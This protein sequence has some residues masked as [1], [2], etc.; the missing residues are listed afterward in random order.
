MVQKQGEIELRRVGVKNDDVNLCSGTCAPRRSTGA[1]RQSFGKQHCL[2][3]EVARCA[4]VYGALRH[5][6]E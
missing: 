6:L 3:L 2:W 5:P 4:G 1:L